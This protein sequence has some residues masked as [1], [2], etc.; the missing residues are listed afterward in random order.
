MADRGLVANVLGVEGVSPAA[1]PVW[2]VFGTNLAGPCFI[3]FHKEMLRGITEYSA[4]RSHSSASALTPLSI[5]GTIIAFTSLATVLNSLS[6]ARFFPSGTRPG[7]FSLMKR[8]SFVYESSVTSVKIFVK[9]TQREG[10]SVF[11]PLGNWVELRFCGF[12]NQSLIALIS[13]LL[14]KG[15][16]AITPTNILAGC[17]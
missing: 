6:D 11:V 1:D 14:G 4:S 5:S 9:G 2:P 10:L 15:K 17:L 8:L 13:D 3:F 12:A 16:N 7:N